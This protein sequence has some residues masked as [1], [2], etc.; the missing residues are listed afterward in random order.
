MPLPDRKSPSLLAA[1]ATI[2]IGVS[3]TQAA[4][5]RDYEGPQ[6]WSVDGESVPPPPDQAP[7]AGGDLP[8]EDA[9]VVP[10]E[11]A[12]AE[13]A[14]S[15]PAAPPPEE[16]S[17]CADGD[18]C[19][20]DLTTDEAALKK[21]MAPKAAPKLAGPSGTL[22]GRMLDATSGSPLIRVNVIVVGTS[23]KT[24]TDIDGRY[25]LSV[26][27]GTYQVRIWYD[28]YEGVTISGVVVAKDDTVA[29]NRDIKPIAG[30]T[31]TVAVTAE[32][33]KESSAGK[34]VERKKS[35][36]ARDM[37]SRDDIRK[38]G[39]G[40]TSAV[41][42]RIVGSTIVGDRFL[43]VRGLGHRY[44]NT[45]FDG[46]RLP[47]PDPNLRTVPL[48]IFPSGALS[49]INVQKTA[50]PD[51]P[52]DFAGASVQ[53][54]SRE[55]PDKWTFQIDGRFGINTQASFQS[56][57]R[58]DHF[59]GDNFAAGNL[60]RDLPDLYNTKQPI[61]ATSMNGDQQA[62][63]PQQIEKFGESLPS[64]NTAVRRH[65]ALP[66]FGGGVQL[67]NTFK[68]WGTRLGFLTALNYANSTQ[69][70]SETYRI[71][72]TEQPTQGGPFSL[73]TRNPDVDIQGTKTT[74]NVQVS[75]LGLLKWKLDQNNR[76]SLLGLYTRDADNESRVLEGRLRTTCGEQFYCR[77]T[78]LRYI[79][80]SVLFTRLGGKHEIPAAKGFTIEWFG[81]YAQARQD[82]PL[83]R[84]MLFYRSVGDTPQDSNYNVD[85]NESGKFQFFK[86]L[87][88][89]GSGALDFTVPFKQWGQL[90]SRFK[91]GAWAEAKRRT[92]G[93][94][95]FDFEPRGFGGQLPSGT[96]NIINAGTIG[97]GSGS[98]EPFSIKEVTR[99]G[100]Q[101]GYAGKQEVY[102][103]YAMLDLP[104]V[105]WLRMVGGA[106]LEANR[107]RV[108]PFDVFGGAVDA[109]A[110]AQIRTLN[111]LPSL[112]LIFAARKDMN[113]RIVGAETV[114]RP[115]FRELAPFVFTDFAG[116]FTVQGYSK[117][118]ATK[119]WNADM[120][121]E[122]F[123]SANE[124][125]AVSVFYKHFDAPIE[126]MIATSPRLQTYRNARFA[127]NVGVELEGR[128]NLEFISKSLRDLS[129]G[130]NFA[131][132]FSRVQIAAP[133]EG[134]LLAPT[135]TQRYL[136]G[137]SPYV[138]NAYLGYDNERS[139][140]NARVLFN[141][142]GRRI[143]FVGGN[144]LPDVYE[145]PIHTMDVTLAQ[146][147]Y[148][149]LSLSFSAFNLLNWRQRFVQG[150]N[151]DIFYTTRRGIFFL[152][153]LSYSI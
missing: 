119:I 103:G 122:W 63:T 16:D 36:A 136:E 108:E 116:G 104:L 37:M 133:K 123:P 34:L 148:K 110:N 153:G 94:R 26:P 60:G 74:Q 52:A 64:L 73:N 107:I 75:G 46:A 134:D 99:P 100:G 40:A 105:R 57:L 87:D 68:P 146:R 90:E 86:L 50:T 71:Y 20:E 53:L 22:S 1:L 21:E 129:L 109:K 35:V 115:E 114:A 19:V 4:G 43:F 28:A 92:F 3:E 55:T 59:A 58:G 83:L 117:L 39:G 147:V 135:S 44:G 88:H 78:R 127:N 47:S 85:T 98:P 67:G 23:Y 143:A 18:F 142:F 84:E 101:D 9:P 56:G 62:F 126:R 15:E 54:E 7:P 27:P 6:G 145:L 51:V 70:L 49:A 102:A 95:T 82:D 112:N 111:V 45:L 11:P 24:K 125:L 13:P 118:T 41:A 61:R 91:F 131:Y 10:S 25:T 149:G 42:R 124:V 32:I 106:R 138:L 79:M 76:V 128:K 152:V 33:N 93:V 38:S 5:P 140:T 65:T 69:T 8:V 130:V 14:P 48:D 2:G 132:I 120:R 121:W 31:Q 30:M 29:I 81:S 89:A 66:N 12:P 77:N 141:T 96:G 150:E 113:V 151:N 137:Q 144:H 72:N 80:R 17:G 97:D 139:G